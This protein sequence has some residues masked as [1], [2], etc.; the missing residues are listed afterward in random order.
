[1]CVCVCVC[2]CRIVAQNPYYKPILERP[3]CGAPGGESEEGER[4]RKREE[5]EERAL[6]PGGEDDS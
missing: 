6:G 3:T 2:V 5:E 1:V 4:A